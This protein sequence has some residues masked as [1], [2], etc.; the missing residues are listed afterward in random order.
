MM[1]VIVARPPLFDLIDAAF[2][3]AGKP[4]VF[5]WGN[6]IYNPTG[7]PVSREIAHHEAVHQKQQ[8]SDPEAWWR[9]Y[10]DDKTFRLEQEIPAHQVQYGEFCLHN[11]NGQIRS[12]RRRYLHL[13]ARR[14]SSPLYG[15]LVPYERARALLKAA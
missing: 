12:N 1:K 7:C 15:S 9:R 5:A 10:I 11:A 6:A 4:V 2:H 13:M 3:V 14:L 8:G